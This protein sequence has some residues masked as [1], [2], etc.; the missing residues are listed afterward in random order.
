MIQ[1]LEIFLQIKELASSFVMAP[2]RL[3]FRIKR[4]NHLYPDEENKEAK[5][6]TAKK[7]IFIGIAR[8]PCVNRLTEVF[9]PFA[10]MHHGAMFA[11]GSRHE[12]AFLQRNFKAFHDPRVDRRDRRRLRSQD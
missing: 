7:R 5:R 8:L 2:Q 10:A 3:D 4:R 6:I 11:L 12:N 9:L 1:I